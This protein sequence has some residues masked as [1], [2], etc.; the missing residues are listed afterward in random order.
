LAE[1]VDASGEDRG[2]RN[3][4]SGAELGGGQSGK[5]EGDEEVLRLGERGEESGGGQQEEPAEIL[6]S[7][8]ASPSGSSE[9]A[10]G[11]GGPVHVE[12]VEDGGIRDVT[13]KEQKCGG[14]EAAAEGM[15][16]GEPGM[17]NA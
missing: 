14:Q 8:V 11:E 15:E 13:E 10:A 12:A 16:L 2:G 6:A 5:R 7:F 1:A 4:A 17:E 3:E 9:K